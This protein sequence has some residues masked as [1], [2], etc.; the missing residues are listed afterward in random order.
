M[1]GENQWGWST[2]RKIKFTLGK[3]EKIDLLS[4]EETVTKFQTFK[5]PSI[6][7]SLQVSFPEE[8]QK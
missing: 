2:W 6:K 1:Q 3:I 5:G 4:G 8:G 7:M